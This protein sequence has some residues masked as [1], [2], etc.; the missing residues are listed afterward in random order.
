MEGKNII[1]LIGGQKTSIKGHIALELG[2]PLWS[3]TFAVD[4][5]AAHA[6]AAFAANTVKHISMGGE[7]NPL[8]LSLSP[9]SGPT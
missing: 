4:K 2:R 1:T 5:S 3:R 7:N 8:K 6:A 9:G